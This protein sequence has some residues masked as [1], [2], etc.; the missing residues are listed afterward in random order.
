M[1]DL[2]PMLPRPQGQSPFEITTPPKQ[3][4]ADRMHEKINGEDEA[5]LKHGC[6]A[7]AAMTLTNADSAATIDI[8][9]YQMATPAAARAI[10]E[11]QTPPDGPTYVDIG[12]KAYTSWGSCYVRAGPLYL[13][14]IAGDAGAAAA[15]ALNLARQ[16]TKKLAPAGQAVTPAVV[17]GSPKTRH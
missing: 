9:L 5:Y 8:Y 3:W 1:A 4:P 16:F 12:D 10:F 15:E 11:E 2:L 14:L 6:L 13:K 17:A 7:L